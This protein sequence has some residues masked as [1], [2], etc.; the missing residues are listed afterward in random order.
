MQ[1]ASDNRVPQ[2]LQ[3]AVDST[4]TAPSRWLAVS[5]AGLALLAAATEAHAGYR[6]VSALLTR[7]FSR[8]AEAASLRNFMVYNCAEP[9]LSALAFV[10]IAVGAFLRSQRAGRVI[11]RLGVL[12]LAMAALLDFFARPFF[13]YTGMS[14]S[15]VLARHMSWALGPLAVNMLIVVLA[16]WFFSNGQKRGLAHN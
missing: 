7:D 16:F 3:Y 4:G 14:L 6:N 5:V 13:Q 15:D 1:E 10:V 11:G 8:E 2:P 9:A 12:L